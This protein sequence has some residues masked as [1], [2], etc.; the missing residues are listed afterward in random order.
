MIVS[1]SRHLGSAAPWL[2]LNTYTKFL[3][4]PQQYRFL[5]GH[6]W[7]L[8]TAFCLCSSAVPGDKRQS[9]L[10]ALKDLQQSLKAA[11]KGGEAGPGGMQR[12]PSMIKRKRSGP[13]RASSAKNLKAEALA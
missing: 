12:S 9:A 13:A 10:S 2:Q 7:W 11:G 8:L 5:W 3:M 4:Q 1:H 6:Q